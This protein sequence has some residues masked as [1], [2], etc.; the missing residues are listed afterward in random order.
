MQ[1][2]FSCGKGCMRDWL[3]PSLH[4]GREKGTNILLSLH[5]LWVGGGYDGVAALQHKKKKRR[6]DVIFS[7]HLL[8]LTTQEEKTGRRRWSYQEG[9]GSHLLSTPSLHKKRER[10]FFSLCTFFG[11]VVGMMGWLLCNTIRKREGRMPS[12]L[13]TF[14]ALQHKKKLWR[15]AVVLPRRD[16]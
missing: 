7:L 16:R 13:S 8:C 5:L 4:R 9:I 15:E 11:L 1:W 2:S 10:T 6:E 14:S 12:S 3:Q